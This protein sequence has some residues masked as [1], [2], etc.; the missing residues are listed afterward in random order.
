[1]DGYAWVH[2]IAAVDFDELSELYRVAPLG[3]K[4]PT[5]LATVFGSS[6][7]RCFVY[8][9]SVRV[10]AGRVLA[11]GLD[12]ALI[13]DVAVHPHHQG[14]G[15]GQAIIRRLVELSAGTRRS[16]CTPTQVPMAS[17][18]RSASSG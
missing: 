8:A 9:D 18:A 4:P 14:R 11:D 15:I 13:A 6:M 5:A 1:M 2:D 3:D 7:F 12:C 17:T 10:G 16:S